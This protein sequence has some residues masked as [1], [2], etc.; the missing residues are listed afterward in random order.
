[1]SSVLGSHVRAR[2]SAS[3]GDVGGVFVVSLQVRMSRRANSTQFLQ[4]VL[5]GPTGDGAEGWLPS[6][7]ALCWPQF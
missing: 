7:L 3:A 1:M 4:C 2:S 5:V 6:L